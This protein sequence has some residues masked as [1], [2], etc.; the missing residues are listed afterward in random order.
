MPLALLLALA[1]IFLWQ[2]NSL[3]N[4]TQLVDGADQ[5]LAQAHLVRELLLDQETGLRGYLI[6]GDQDFLTPYQRGAV[7]MPKALDDLAGQFAG[8]PGQLALVDQ[9]RGEYAQ[10]AQYA[11]DVIALRDGGGDYAA[12]VRQRIGKNR[13]DAMRSDITALIMSEE[14]LRDERTQMAQ[15]TTLLVIGSSVAGAL[16]LGAMLVFF[17]RR[18]LLTLSHNYEGALDSAR[19]G[20]AALGRSEEQFR[21]LAELVPQLIWI[22]RPDGYHDYFNQRWYDYTGTTLEQTRGEGWSQLLHP[23]DLERTLETWHHSLRTGEPYDIEYRFKEARTGEYRWFLGRAVPAR[24]ERG[25][26][27]RWFGTCT[28]I[29]DQKR[30]AEALQERTEELARIT[31]SLEERN[32]ELDQFAYVTSHDLKA[33]LRGIANL[34]QWIEE[35][36]GEQATDD[37]RKQLDLLRGRV[38]RM[39]ALI[40]GI[41]QFSRVGR[42]QSDLEPVDVGALLHD[43]ADLLGAPPE[44]T[45][46]IG[47][48]MPTITTERLR[49]QQVFANLLGNAVK[50]RS[51]PD[52]HACVRVA[53]AGN[54][55][56]FAVSDDGPGIAPQYHDRIFVIF[57]TLA[58]RDAVEGSGLGLS[59]VKKIVENHGGRIWVE[60][61]EGQGATFRF[62]WPKNPPKRRR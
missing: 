45:I 18:Q 5:T 8:R 56:E 1:V 62:T 28:D 27:T 44:Y 33:P 40:D 19:E 23:D 49:L 16:V 41:L 36:L 48:D 15:R 21:L 17:V 24:D 34:S 9:I 14:Q 13:M 35:D 59:L 47:P 42:V 43:V 37:I 55:Y 39:E 58:P 31:T 2:V 50:H 38:H 52:G 51:R 53:D 22:T 29:D 3:L 46:E 26:I 20:A 6:A 30:N 32:R 54:M 10:W 57:Q 25:A 61:A 12:I 11:R 60:S 7:S 4:A